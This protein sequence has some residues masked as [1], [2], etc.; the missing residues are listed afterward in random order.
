MVGPF[1]N[2]LAPNRNRPSDGC[3]SLHVL[4]ELSDESWMRAWSD[5][6][7]SAKRENLLSWRLISDFSRR[8]TAPLLLPQKGETGWYQ[9]LARRTTYR[10]Q[11]FG[12][13]CYYQTTD[14]VISY[15]DTISSTTLAEWKVVASAV[16]WGSMGYNT[17]SRHLE[18]F[19][20]Q[21]GR[22]ES[23]KLNDMKVKYDAI[24]I[25]AGCLFPNVRDVASCILI[26]INDARLGSP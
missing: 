16:P 14:F 12:N 20:A 11:W 1:S 8:I 15:P 3:S 17:D 7:N 18:P 26:K 21:S 2:A 9:S 22:T 4:N 24:Y 13:S 6:T 5:S 23:K 10:P 25:L 19:W